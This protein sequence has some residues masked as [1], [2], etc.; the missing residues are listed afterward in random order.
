MCDGAW[1]SGAS[2]LQYCELLATYLS[3]HCKYLNHFERIFIH[4]LL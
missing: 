2:D 4:T 3:R 1:V